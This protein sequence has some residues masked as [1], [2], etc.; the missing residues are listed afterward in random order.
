MKR[1]TAAALMATFAAL[2]CA[3]EHPISR[4]LDA[5]DA[6]ALTRDAVASDAPSR[7]AVASDAPS[8]RDAMD[9]VAPDVIVD[10][11]G[12]ELPD[13]AIDVS[14]DLDAPD[15]PEAVDAPDVPEAID[16][17]D[18]PEAFD[19]PDVPEA[20]DAP[21]VP[22]VVD[23]PDVPAP[24]DVADVPEAVD[25]PDVPAPQD[26]VDVPA[27]VDSG[28]T[29]YASC[30]AARLA[31]RPSGAYVIRAGSTTPWLA[32]CD[33]S[34]AAGAWTLVLKADGRQSTFAYDSPLWGNLELLNP[35]SAN[36]DRVEAKFPGFV[37]LPVGALRVQVVTP[38]DGSLSNAR[39]LVLPVVGGL[40]LQL[41]FLSDL[42]VNYAPVTTESQWFGLVPG[43]S[44]QDR[45]I[46]RGLNVRSNNRGADRVRVGMIGNENRGA[47][48]CD[49]HDSR[50][51]VGGAGAACG[52][53][54]DTNSV[55]NAAGCNGGGGDRDLRSFAYLWVR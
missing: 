30:E 25:A 35:S 51:G 29:I 16:A 52:A 20:F 27:V 8:P 22:E 54:R 50:L 23:A 12:E 42:F 39:E 38:A 14:V 44:L 3:L 32:Y 10:A 36:L 11:G 34:P 7:D 24:Q 6:D 4:E 28:P 40:T 17:P 5:G 26:V 1:W 55:G 21:D 47:G 19:A 45:C 41:I 31:G 37:G 13:A 18:V 46:R 2:G 15:V 49:S 9:A 43:S 48:E 33:T 53:P